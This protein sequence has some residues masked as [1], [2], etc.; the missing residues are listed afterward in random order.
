MKDFYE[1][2]P[3]EEIIRPSIDGT[4]NVI[5]SCKRANVRRIVATSS[6]ATVFC[7]V[8]TRPVSQT[9]TEV[10]E[11]NQSTPG[12][13]TYPYAKREAEKILYT[14]WPGELVTIHPPMIIGPPMDPTVKTSLE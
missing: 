10:D 1:K 3:Y 13:G 11:N 2:D 7:D 6:V 5:K 8:G 4:R 14:E 9:Y 12:K